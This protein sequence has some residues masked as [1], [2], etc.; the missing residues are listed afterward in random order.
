L[1][2]SIPD[3]EYHLFYFFTIY[4]FVLNR[5]FL[6]SQSNYFLTRSIETVK[7]ILYIRYTSIEVSKEMFR[8]LEDTNFYETPENTDWIPTNY[9]IENHEI[10]C[11]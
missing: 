6:G 10:I 5:R 9:L 11:T 3:I 8:L 1:L 7:C 4:N 2:F